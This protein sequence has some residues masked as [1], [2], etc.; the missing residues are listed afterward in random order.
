MRNRGIP[1]VN[2]VLSDLAGG[3]NLTAGAEWVLRYLDEAPRG[4]GWGSVQRFEAVFRTGLGR[5]EI[6]VILKSK[7]RLQLKSWR[8]F[9]PQT[10]VE[11][12][13]K[14]WLLSGRQPSGF[15]WI[16]DGGKDLGSAADDPEGRRGRPAGRMEAG[17]AQYE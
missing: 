16:F 9:R 8:T 3:G 11:Q 13:E 6:D 5:R 10:L 14:D 17:E 12:I 2:A 7:L 1:G 4:R 15:L